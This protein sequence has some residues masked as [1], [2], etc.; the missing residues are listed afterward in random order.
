MWS[1][2]QKEYREV[3][4]DWLSVCGCV[5]DELLS[6]KDRRRRQS[7]DTSLLEQRVEWAEEEGE[8]EKMKEQQRQTQ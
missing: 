2:Q 4:R 6:G 1:Q 3:E 8:R 7:D 5:R